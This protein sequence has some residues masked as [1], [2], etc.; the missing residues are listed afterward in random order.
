M[1]LDEKNKNTKWAESEN[2]EIAQLNEYNAFQ[3]KGYKAP[4]PQGYKK[5]QVHMVYAV[6]HPM[7]I[8]LSIFRRS[9]IFR[10]PDIWED[11]GALVVPFSASPPP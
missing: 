3:D 5:I 4:I 11:S 7:V 8:F 9:W 6:N 2:L 1:R 10:A